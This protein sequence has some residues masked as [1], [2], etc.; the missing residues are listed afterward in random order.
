MG[1][2]GTE[3]HLQGKLRI[4]MKKR[5]WIKMLVNAYISLSPYLF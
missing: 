3:I 1:K 4:Y 2:V 5:I